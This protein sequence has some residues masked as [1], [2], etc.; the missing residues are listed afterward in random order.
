ML[1]RHAIALLIILFGVLSYWL[2]GWLSIPPHNQ[3][4]QESRLNIPRPPP[5]GI[6]S[7]GE[8]DR[9]KQRVQRVSMETIEPQQAIKMVVQSTSYS[10]TGSRT[11]TGTWP[12]EGRTIAVD[13]ATIPINSKVYIKELDNWYVAED[14]IPPK[15]IAKGARVDVFLGDKSRCWE[16]G[17][18]DITIE[19]VPPEPQ[20]IP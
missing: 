7:R 13:P 14:L 10:H 5:L 15:S 16:W 17:R 12:Q 19:V 8:V 18:R 2:I 3:P 9:N 6:I 20:T 4:T 1:N 11:Y